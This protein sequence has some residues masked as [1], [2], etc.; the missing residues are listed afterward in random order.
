MT[1][2]KNNQDRFEDPTYNVPRELCKF[3]DTLELNG[4]GAMITWVRINEEQG[5]IETWSV[6][7][8]NIVIYN[9]KGEIVW[10]NE[11][12]Q[13]TYANYLKKRAAVTLLQKHENNP[14]TG[15]PTAILHACQ[16]L[17]SEIQRE[18]QQGEKVDYGTLFPE[19]RLKTIHIGNLCTGIAPPVFSLTKME[20]L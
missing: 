16:T 7:D 2:V 17:E 18:H 10:S 5:C 11:S 14:E 6:G 9:N 15:S 8:A 12:Q 3:L 20:S 13:T 4:S 1:F 19:Q